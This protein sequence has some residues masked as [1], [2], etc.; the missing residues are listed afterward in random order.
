MPSL[1]RTSKTTRSGEGLESGMPNWAGDT[2]G[3]SPDASASNA[4]NAS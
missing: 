2:T 1:T 4:D 3:A